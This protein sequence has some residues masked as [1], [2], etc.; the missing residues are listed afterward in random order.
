MTL[1]G[2]PLDG[3][4][5]WHFSG[6]VIFAYTVHRLGDEYFPVLESE[7]FGWP[8]MGVALYVQDLP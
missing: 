6:Y 5:A 3:M 1:V 2:G 4:E 7:Y 8:E